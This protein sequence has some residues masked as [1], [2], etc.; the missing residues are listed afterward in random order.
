MADKKV[1]QLTEVT[2]LPDNSK[3][4]AVDLSRAEGDRDVQISKSNL[5]PASKS[6]FTFFIA[7]SN[8]SQETKDSADFVCDGTNDEL[9]V[10]NAISQLPD[11]YSSGR[12]GGTILFSE[13]NFYFED[14]ISITEVMQITLQGMGN[15]TNFWM[16]NE[17]SPTSTLK[18]IISVEHASFSSEAWD[19]TNIK[20]IFFMSQSQ[21]NAVGVMANLLHYI[22][23]DGCMF[24]GHKMTGVHF[25]DVNNGSITNNFFENV[26]TGIKGVSDVKDI[27]DI[28]ILNN[29]F[30][31]VRGEAIHLVAT[32]ITG[33][34]GI[35]RN[36][37]SNNII[38]E[39]NSLDE[40]VATIYI[41]KGQNLNISNNIISES[42]GSIDIYLKDCEEYVS[43]FDNNI[44]EAATGILSENCTGLEIRFNQIDASV[45]GLDID[46]NSS[47]LL[48]GNNSSV[49]NNGAIDVID[50]DS[51]GVTASNFIKQGGLST[52][53]LMADGTTSA[54]ATP[55]QWDDTTGGINYA[56]GN[57]GIGQDSPTSKLY[58]NSGGTETV[59]TF[60][61]TDNKAR[62]VVSDNDTNTYIIA[63]GDK[64]SVGRSASLTTTNITIDSSG[65]LGVG[66]ITPSSKLHVSGGDV[67]VEDAG[68]GLVIKSPDG[69]RFRIS[70]DNSGVLSATTV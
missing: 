58:V 40:G 69:T 46:S 13:G 41:E 33:A 20:D 53:F 11:V 26:L 62:I 68:S 65:N 7:S 63:E 8:A 23:I 37:L 4:Y 42:G 28:L 22:F 52:E 70:V 57:V 50:L 24:K 25:T 59:A 12:R 10:N 6:N 30:T 2:T 29:H 64:S 47:A 35:S 45:N 38:E 21:V 17:A 16:I 27:E 32:E 54:G 56:S 51:N 44:T 5:I 15:S 48:I 31:L 19:K 1:S 39:C 34:K 49:Q 36:I 14:P 3:L 66:N 9:V 67:E 43:V 61:S 55:T 18:P 60:K